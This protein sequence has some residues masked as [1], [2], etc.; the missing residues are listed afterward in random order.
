MIGPPRVCQKAVQTGIVSS[1]GMR[2]TPTIKQVGTVSIVIT[3]IVCAVVLAFLSNSTSGVLSKALTPVLLLIIVAA[4]AQLYRIHLVQQRRQLR[5]HK[6]G[7]KL[8]HIKAERRRDEAL[9]LKILNHI[10]ST[11]DPVPEHAKVWQKPLHGFSGDLA[12]AYESSCGKKY[13]LLADL[14]GHGIAAAIGAAPVAS[15]F[16]ATTKKGWTVEKIVTELN[17]RLQELLPSGFFC[18]AAIV[19]EDEGSITICNAGLP[20]ILIINNEGQI[21]NCVTS[22]QLPLGIQSIGVEDVIVVTAE[23]HQ[24][25]QL[26]AFTDGLIET[27]SANDEVFDIDVLS[28]LLCTQNQGFGRIKSIMDSFESFSKDSLPDDDISIVEVK[29][30]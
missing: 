6:L 26:Y 15:I 9:A 20:E 21:V 24:Q 4:Q 11:S 1:I 16:R 13:T 22:A 25:H 2:A 3:S 8:V 19:M 10:N 23:Y 7:R 5:F 12:L 18:C 14:T 27:T 29:I 17:N 28:D 30:C